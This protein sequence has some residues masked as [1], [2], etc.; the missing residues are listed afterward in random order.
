MIGEGFG[1]LSSGGSSMLSPDT[2]FFYVSRARFAFSIGFSA[3][4]K[5]V[6]C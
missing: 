4:P 1:S 5:A 3:S 6:Q 2:T